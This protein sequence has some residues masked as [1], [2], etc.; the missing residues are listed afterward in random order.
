MTNYLVKTIIDT[1]FQELVID[2][3]DTLPNV[4]NKGDRYILST[5]SNI[6][7]YD[8]SIWL[9]YLPPEFSICFIKNIGCKKILISGRWIDYPFIYEELVNRK[10]RTSS[11]NPV[12]IL[13]INFNL[14][15]SSCY[16]LDIIFQG[17]TTSDRWFGYT[18]SKA[19]FYNDNI[20][21]I[22]EINIEDP[23]WS[24]YNIAT[25]LKLTKG[26][27]TIDVYLSNNRRRTA[28]LRNPKFLLVQL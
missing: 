7:Y 3:V 6:Y 26:A 11:R 12:K 27:H 1:G 28:Y 20:D 8:G 19:Y 18:I 21:L 9:H 17:K 5:D 15:I 13:T 14:S 25:I 10:F 23:T 24:S 16:R 2:I 4:P 22:Q